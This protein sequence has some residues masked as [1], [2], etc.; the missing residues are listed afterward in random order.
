MNF[1]K[2]TQFKPFIW[3]IIIFLLLTVSTTV[4]MNNLHN[5]NTFSKDTFKVTIKGQVQINSEILDSRFVKI[6]SETLLYDDETRLNTQPNQIAIGNIVGDGKKREY[7]VTFDLERPTTL[8]ISAREE[9]CNHKRVFVD[10]NSEV[11]ELDLIVDNNICNVGTNTNDSNTQLRK[12]SRAILISSEEEFSKIPSNKTYKDE[13]DQAIDTGWNELQATSGFENESEE[14]IFLLRAY[15]YAMKSRIGSQIFKVESCYERV[16]PYISNSTCQVYPYEDINTIERAENFANYMIFEFRKMDLSNRNIST[17]INEI[18]FME[19]KSE[20]LRNFLYNCED[21][22]YTIIKNYNQQTPTCNTT[23]AI[24]LL[25]NFSSTLTVF[26]IG[27][28]ATLLI[29]LPLKDKVDKLNKK[30]YNNISY[31]LWVITVMGAS[32]ILLL[33]ALSIINNSWLYLIPATSFGGLTALFPKVAI[34][35]LGRLFESKEPSIH[36]STKQ[37]MKNSDGSVQIGEARD[38]YVDSSNNNNKKKKKKIVK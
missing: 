12:I 19:G 27:M 29:M 23:K 2:Y 30:T 33:Q 31:I 36:K 38:V 17:L 10:E 8:I 1:K 6:Y 18:K 14:R 22:Q 20:E 3:L 21:S 26:L 16:Q 24:K 5:Y 35:L 13:L 4:I 37:T 32:L 7:V 15:Y 11:I 9:G 25:N 34:Q 28:F